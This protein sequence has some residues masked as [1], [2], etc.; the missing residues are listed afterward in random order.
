MNI[1]RICDG[2]ISEEGFQ[3]NIFRTSRGGTPVTS[4]EGRPL[5]NVLGLDSYGPDG[6]R[7]SN[8]DGQFDFRPGFTIDEDKGELI[9][10][11]LRP[12][13]DGIRG[14]F[15][16]RGVVV[17]DSF[18]YPQLY[19]TTSEAATIYALFDTYTISGR[20]ASK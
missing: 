13:D 4:I 1:Y 9:F 5:L 19:D 18:L 12:L 16:A 11:Y 6:T 7:I 3:L 17:P 15:A 14:Y 20:A 2:P 10:P 8:G